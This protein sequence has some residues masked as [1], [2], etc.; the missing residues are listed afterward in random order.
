MKTTIQIYLNVHRFL[1]QKYR[2]SN[3]EDAKNNFV[4][5]AKERDDANANPRRKE[6][7]IEIQSI[8]N[9]IEDLK[10][11]IKNDT[12]VQQDLRRTFETQSA[13]EQL[14]GQC[15]TA[16]EDLKEKISDYRFQFQAY[17]VSPPPTDLPGTSVDKRGE[18]LKRVMVAVSDEINDKFQDKERELIKHEEA[19]R[20]IEAIV[21][22][23]SA[24]YNRDVQSIRSNQQRLSELKPSVEKT[25]RV[26]KELR[27]FEAHE[28][29]VST[30]AVITENRPGEL[31]SYLTK[32]IEDIESHST[33]GIPPQTIKA[34]IKKLFKLVRRIPATL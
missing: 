6:I 30:P 34:V 27:S 3:L 14:K 9:K 20:R 29:G 15:E 11:K 16:L 5:A 26:V 31:L 24:L 17:K 2:K 21:S 22:E 8:G 10:V 7:P 25:Q 28:D 33:E 18:E 4:K 23:K 12:E 32:R 13:I 1:G 19:I